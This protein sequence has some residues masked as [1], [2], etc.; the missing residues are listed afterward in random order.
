MTTG[1]YDIH[2]RAE[3]MHPNAIAAG[4]AQCEE[5]G[6]THIDGLPGEP[7]IR[8]VDYVE[9]LT[10]RWRRCC[11]TARAIDNIRSGYCTILPNTTPSSSDARH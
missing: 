11:E 2:D 9:T 1:L 8:V 6:I 5:Q 10:K 3:V 7:V 4:Q